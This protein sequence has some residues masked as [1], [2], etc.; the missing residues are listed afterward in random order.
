MSRSCI[1]SFY[2]TLG[3]STEHQNP[4]LP[5]QDGGPILLVHKFSPLWDANPGSHGGDFRISGMHNR[6]RRNSPSGTRRREA[7]LPIRRARKFVEFLEFLW[8][9][10][11]LCTILVGR[12]GPFDPPV[13]CRGFFCA[14]SSAIR[15]SR[16]KRGIRLDQSQMDS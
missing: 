4:I 14:L 8:T 11:A 6:G 15:P 2:P 5:R 13:C 7:S 3:A 1:V 12:I 10:F 9:R 16:G